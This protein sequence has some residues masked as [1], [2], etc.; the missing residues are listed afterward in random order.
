VPL[1]WGNS[2]RGTSYGIGTWA[3]WQVRSWWR[4]SPGLRAVHEHFSFVPGAFEVAGLSQAG[5]DPSV[6]ALLTTSMDVG[7]RWSIDGTWR[8]V[9]ALP[10]PALPSYQELDARIGWRATQALELAIGGSNLLHA[11]HL[12][13]PQPGGEY[14]DRAVMASVIYK[15]L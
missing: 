2:E 8:Y 13:S 14:I 11:H 1:A 9:G 7:R 4:I 15:P 10:N 12:E 6:T 3:D 5:D